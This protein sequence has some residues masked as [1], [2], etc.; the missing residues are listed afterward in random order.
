VKAAALFRARYGGAPDGVWLAPG[1]ANL[2]GEH[3]DYNEGYVL[4]FAL[5]EHIVA[6]AARRADGRL[7][8]CSRQADSEVAVTVADLAPGSVT[9]WAAYPAGVAWALRESGCRL[10]GACVAID[11]DVPQGA[12]LSSSA[13]LECATALALTDLA[14]LVIPRGELAAIA[15]RAENE[16]VGVPSGIM[17]QSASLLCRAGH[18][19]LLDCRSLE[20]AQVPL[21]PAA[22]GTAVLLVNTRARHELGGGEYGR[23]RAECEQAAGQLGIGSLRDLTDLA[24]LA[25]LTDPVLRRR[26]RHVVTDNR[27]VLEVVALLNSPSGSYRDIGQLVTQAHLSLRDDFEISW[28]QADAAVEAA[29]EAGALGARMMGGGFGGSV[30][31]LVPAAADGA[32][33]AA[34]AA[35]FAR[36]AWPEPEFLD[37]APS[38]GARRLSLRPFRGEANVAVRDAAVKLA[39]ELAELLSAGSSIALKATVRRRR[40]VAEP[41]APGVVQPDVVCGPA[42]AEDGEDA[43]GGEDQGDDV[44]GGEGKPKKRGRREVVE[45]TCEPPRRLQLNPKADQG[46]SAAPGP[47]TCTNS[48][49]ARWQKTRQDAAWWP[50]FITSWCGPPAASHPLRHSRR[51]EEGRNWP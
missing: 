42:G 22:M 3:T 30:L 26:A 15:R 4:P 18:A 33:R 48:M 8:L 51:P 44:V 5:P 27:R 40:G 35:A 9:G 19:L 28:P 25:R 37:A 13:A 17:D 16:F 23:R 36:H 46:P 34:V 21:D 14:G 39:G 47:H 31:A 50:R 45:C 20:A 6:A 29:L 7:L 11:S 2:M 38:A 49:S 24:Q 32:V 43:G 12:G 10:P 1:R 41:L